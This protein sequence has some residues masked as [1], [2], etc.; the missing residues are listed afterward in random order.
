M[1]KV[2]CLESGCGELTTNPSKCDEHSPGKYTGLNG[3]PKSTYGNQWRKLSERLRKEQPW[4][5]M[6]GYDQDLTVDHVIPGT[7]AGGLIVLCRSCNSR[8]SSRDKKLR[9]TVGELSKPVF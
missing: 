3:L 5:T 7:I 4:C 1:R 9:Q 8:K 2:I 6:C